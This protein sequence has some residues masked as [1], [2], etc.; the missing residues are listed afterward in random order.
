MYHYL[1]I[2]DILFRRCCVLLMLCWGICHVV[3]AEKVDVQKA[4]RVAQRYV[5]SRQRL[6]TTDNVHLK[7]TATGRRGQQGRIQRLQDEQEAVYYYVFDI[8]ENAGGGF[9]IVAGD[10]V[11]R[12]VLGYST[13]GNYDEN[14]LP[15]NFACWMN[16][17]QQE[18][19]DAQTKD[20]PQSEDMR[21]EWDSYMSGMVR[22]GADVV[23][24]LLKTTWN[25]FAPYNNLCPTYAD[26]RTVTGCVATAMAQ[27]MNYHRNPV[28]GM[29]ESE[30]YTTR[31]LNIEVPSV[32]FEVNYDWANMLNSYSGN[33]TTQ[34]Q[35]AVAT[36]MYHC[37]A[38]VKMD[39]AVDESGASS[40]N[41]PVALTTYFGYD[42]SI[43][44]ISRGNSDNTSWE[45]MIREQ[46]D[47]G[48]PVYYAGSS[49]CTG[50][51]FVCD[52]YDNSGL[53]HFNWGWGGAYDGYFVT[54]SLNPGMSFNNGQEIIVHIKP[55]GV[56]YLFNSGSGA[57]DDPYIIATPAQLAN[58]SELMND[59]NVDYFDKHYKLTANLDLSR[60]GAN[61][62]GGTGWIPI[63]N[64]GCPFKGK[65]D[66]NNKTIT[67]LYINTTN[68]YAGLFGCM[69][70]S[71]MIQNLGIEN[72]NVRGGSYV[73][74]VTGDMNNGNITGC[75]VTGS[76]GGNDI[77]VGG[78]AG[79]V[80]NSANLTNCYT[81]GTVYGINQVGGI[82][83]ATGQNSSI[84]NCYS[85][86]TVNGGSYVGGVAGC[87]SEGG[88]LIN[89]AALNPIVK[90]NIHVGRVTGEN[91]GALSDNI[92]FC[93]MSSDD[94]VDFQ[95]VNIADG[96]DGAG[97]S[98]ADLQTETGLPSG[99]TTSLWTYEE[100]MLPG[101]FGETVDMPEY[102]R[103][104]TGTS[105]TKDI[106]L[107]NDGSV[108]LYPV[109]F[110]EHDSDIC[111]KKFVFVVNGADRASLTLTCNNI[112]TY[113]V[114]IVRIDADDNRSQPQIVRFTIS[115]KTPPVF[116]V[117][118]QVVVLNEIGNTTV[119]PVDFVRNIADNCSN[120]QDITFWFVVDGADRGSLSFSCNDLGL[121][122]LSVVAIDGRGNRSQP[123]EVSCTIRS[124]IPPDYDVI[125]DRDISLDDVGTITIYP[126]DFVENVCVY[127]G[128]ENNIIF[129]FD[130][131]GVDYNSLTFTC[132]DID[133]YVVSIVAIPG[134][135]SRSQPKVVPFAISDQI[136][137]DVHC[138]SV[139][140]L[141]DDDGKATL[142]VEMVDNQSIDNCGIESILIKKTLDSDEQYA[143]SVDFTIEDYDIL[144]GG[145]SSVTLRVIDESENESTCTASVQLVVQIPPSD[146]KDIPEIFT[147][148]GD[149]FND[150]WDI[151]EMDQYPEATIR[152][153]NRTKRLVI[154]LKGA[155]MP[156]DGRDRN[157]NL[158]ESDY[159]LYQ[160]E[161]RRGGKVISGYVTILR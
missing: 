154:E 149:G 129:M 126:V 64:S 144:L 95:G 107:D 46:I 155:Q 8:N 130:V 14:N 75:Y 86:S 157:G 146:L 38:S 57:S 23:V 74:G 19:A 61:W 54:T 98:G 56:Q 147:P 18:I 137:P 20:L 78:I 44:L 152:I 37:G 89:C 96:L 50:H 160:I 29:G 115:D 11:V 36:L 116:D 25:Q 42:K 60:Y 102:L 111:D 53:F 161:L 121:R 136:P 150:T 16:N 40:A 138:K 15:P 73:G 81:T 68:D 117:I 159:Y 47:M 90:G 85:M 110:V 92:A 128:N 6:R 22:Y 93:N 12:P 13:G 2:S 43:M 32:N 49:P 28:R 133:S 33:A 79:R 134:Q 158:L 71:A 100:G 67:G 94:G 131:N 109:V 153:F 77:A 108:T 135:C 17:L 1:H 41:V 52:G 124:L 72:A 35:N 139:R 7:Y 140:L 5:E 70:E 119:Y 66:G 10:D 106:A 45:N 76:V 27:I 34:Q 122:T 101:L 97:R 87:V 65:F 80:H 123:K 82:A 30:A 69:A 141:L 118:S 112:G 103:F 113:T 88:N 26:S 24:P 125:P 3:Q 145:S 148:N 55:E 9:V 48:L 58:L 91:N 99:F 51:A 142:T 62:N 114:S 105:G 63:G 59:C 127:E 84:I 132:D 156:W 151:P 31:T 83:G 120:E 4:G 104:S 143:E 39:Y 21:Q